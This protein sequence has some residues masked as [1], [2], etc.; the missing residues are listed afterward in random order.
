MN[1]KIKLS[2]I[3]ILTI[4][5]VFMGVN[6]VSAQVSYCNAYGCYANQPIVT[7][8]P[9]TVIGPTSATLNGY[10]SPN[11]PYTTRWFEWG[12]NSNY[13][14]SST[15]KVSLVSSPVNFS[16]SIYNLMPN[17]TYYYRTVAQNS[18]GGIIT[19]GNILIFKTANSNL[20][21]TYT[22]GVYDA[23]VPIA[24][25]T[26]ATNINQSSATLGGLGLGGS[27]IYFNGYFEYGTTQALGNTTA[28]K[29][30]GSEQSNSF[31][32]SLSD[33][34]SGVTYYYR[35]V[36]LNQYGISRGDIL[37]FTTI[38]PT[39]YTKSVTTSNTNS[40][41]ATS[42]SSVVSLNVSRNNEKIRKG[43]TIEYV[44]NYK[45]TSSKNLQNVVLQITIPKEFQFME[46]SRGYFSSDNSIVLANIGDLASKE[47]GNVNVRVTITTD[48]QT[49]KIVVVTANL[50]YTT[51]TNTQ[52]EIFAYTKNNVEDTSTTAVQQGGLAFLAGGNF[53]PN[54]LLGWLLLILVITLLV[55]A[56]RKA[57]DGSNLVLVQKISTKKS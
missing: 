38:S 35:A 45:N 22:N 12:T 51:S 6:I 39:V 33:L 44:I 50:A 54:T 21:N 27:N 40:V 18:N 53:F 4:L 15:N 56:A 46:A 8:Y 28:N 23:Y 9:A 7:T 19:Y 37:S 47:E 34:A 30:I 3:G 25:T 41:V 42:K 16:E 32:E 49:G 1:I 57:Y 17:T 11:D 43:D 29:S 13:L 48:A 55:L 2:I 24:V 31:Y 10:I 14:R 36:V 5:S 26:P 20:F 52:G